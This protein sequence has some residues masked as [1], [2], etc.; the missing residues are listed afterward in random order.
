MIGLGCH[1]AEDDPGGQAGELSDPV[2]RENAIFN[3]KAIYAETLAANGGDRNSA[4][5]KAVADV[6]VGPL[7][8]AYLDYP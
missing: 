6:T 2:R 4:D 7:T 8:Q 3:I 5:V 1:A